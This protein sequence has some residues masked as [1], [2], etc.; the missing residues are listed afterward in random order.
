MD[1]VVVGEQFVEDGIEVEGESS[2]DRNENA[3]LGFEM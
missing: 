1:I 3:S 2:F